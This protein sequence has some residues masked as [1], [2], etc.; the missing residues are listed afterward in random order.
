MDMS[1]NTRIEPSD[2]RYEQIYRF[3][4]KN[5]KPAICQMEEVQYMALST[6]GILVFI[7][8]ARSTS[9]NFGSVS[10]GSFTN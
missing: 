1:D 5:D 3:W 4:V 2:E 10:T 9:D 8:L 6:D 7:R